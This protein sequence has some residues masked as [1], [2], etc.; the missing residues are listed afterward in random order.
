MMVIK[1]FLIYC[2]QEIKT[3][4]WDAESTEDFEELEHEH[5]GG[6]L[7]ADNTDTKNV[8]GSSDVFGS[9]IFG[10]YTDGNGDRADASG[11][12]ESNEDDK[13]N[14]DVVE[15]APKQR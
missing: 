6:G 7:A 15:V 10:E 1:D 5:E 11:E 9:D 2:K 13:D 12:N 3:E 14:N 8:T 4:P